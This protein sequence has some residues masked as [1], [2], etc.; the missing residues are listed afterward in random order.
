MADI[1]GCSARILVNGHKVREYERDEDGAIFV[2]SKHGSEY[3]ILLKNHLGTKVL[4]VVS[5]DGL[6]VISGEPATNNSPGYILRPNSS[7]RV[8]G[9]RKDDQTVGSF[10]FVN[11]RKSYSKSRGKGGNEGV[12]SIRFFDEE[13]QLLFGNSQVITTTYPQPYTWTV[14]NN[15]PYIGDP[16]VNINQVDSGLVNDGYTY[17]C[18]SNSVCPS[19]YGKAVEG[20]LSSSS[21]FQSGTTWGTKKY[22]KVKQRDFQR[23]KLRGEINFYYTTKD[24]LKSLGVP[25]IEEKYVSYPRGFN[26]YA[27]PPKG[28]E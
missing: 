27:T 28:W 23:G 3:E 4:A 16:V 1:H 6:D 15:Q 7:M 19:D 5:V 22:D 8:K 12:I 10:R 18:S 11:K 2:E 13:K 24:G 17:S 14:I 20:K 21:P 26:N 9:F 25:V